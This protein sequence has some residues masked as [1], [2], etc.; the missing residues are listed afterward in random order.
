MKTSRRKEASPTTLRRMSVVYL[1]MLLF[2]IACLAKILYLSIVERAVASGTSDKCVDTTE[3]GWEDLANDD[4]YCFVRENTLRPVRGEIYDDHGRVLVANFTVFEVAFDGK[5]FVKEYGDTL[6]KNPNAFDSIF[7]K[8]ADDFY[9]QF[10]DRFPRYDA[11]YYYDFFKKNVKNKHYATLFPVKDWDE[12]SWVM[13][14][15]TAFIKNRPYLFKTVVVADKKIS[16]REKRRA[17]RQGVEA[18]PTYDTLRVAVMHP[19]FNYVSANVR[20][21]PY[22]EMAK[23]TLG[24]ESPERQ[25]GLEHSMN[26]ILGGVEGSKKYLELNHAK[27]PLRDRMDPVDGYNIHTT[28]K[29]EIQHAVHNELSRKLSELNAEWGCAIVMETKT[30]EI[31]AIS[32]LRRAAPDASYYTESM[33]YA[34]NAK[35]EP[36]STFKLA[37]LLAY[38]EKVPNDTVGRYR[39]YKNTFEFPTKSGKILKYTKVDHDYPVLDVSALEV[40]KRS[41][42]VGIAK[43]IFDTYG[44]RGF[45]NYLEQLRKFGLLDTVH[46]QLGDLLPARIKDGTND[47]NTYYATCFGAGF[48]IPIIRTLIYYNAIANDGKMM[49]PM[50]VRYVTDM[51]DTVQRFEPQVLMDSIASASTV[52]K[53]RYYLEQVVWGEHGTAYRY[54]D[55]NCMFAGKTGTRDIWDEQMGCYRKDINAVSFC[56]YFPMDRPQYTVIVYI[57][58]VPQMSSVAVDAFARIARSIMNS[59]NYSA[60][61]SAADFPFTPLGRTAPIRRKY[62]N[63]L[64]NGLGYDT[65]DYETPA[66]YLRVDAADTNRHV[67]VRALPLTQYQKMPDVRGMLASDAVTE[68][69]RAGYKVRISGKGR[70]KSQVLDNSSG[71]VKIYLDP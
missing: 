11:D 52:R 38:L 53:A 43:M 6:S 9:L 41:S 37:S 10:K 49:A 58:G 4:T 50:F 29:L 55:E 26:D 14:V 21:N 51:Y 28:L 68:L 46:S 5:G 20:I 31:K 42:N 35:V 47:F 44:K 48:N 63:T 16:K 39:I 3:P 65:V 64:L 54:R 27:V 36:G 45:A 15:D 13:G 32:N 71:I 33:E 69:I 62:F 59:S 12:K 2:G 66:P 19:H 57:Y 40:F 61:R 24:V 1:L 8:L 18:E 25:Y 70:V 60:T 30:G 7:R 67:S 56:G 34:L 23:R 22:G 17:K